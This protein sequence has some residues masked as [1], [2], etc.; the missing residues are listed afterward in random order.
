M[1]RQRSQ[2]SRSF[3]QLIITNGSSE[4][5]LKTG[6]TVTQSLASGVPKLGLI[7][8]VVLKSLCDQAVG[9]PQV[10]HLPFSFVLN[11]Y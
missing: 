1:E 7:H 10:P 5:P 2:E 6:M 8:L 3:A 9:H 11:S 4:S